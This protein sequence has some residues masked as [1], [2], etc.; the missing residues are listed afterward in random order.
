[1]YTRFFTGVRELP[2]SD[3]AHFTQIDYDRD[4]AFVAVGCDAAGA[5]EIHGVARAC[6]DPDNHAA[7]FAV[8]VRSDL[9][10]QGLGTLLMRK[11]IRY[12]RERGTRELWGDVMN[13]NTAMLQL[14]RSLGFRV[15][16]TELNIETVAL[17]LQAP[18]AAPDSRGG[19]KVEAAK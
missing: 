3:L 8:L 14:S 17:D 10:G 19:G 5:G 12:C 4:M 2:D 13:D 16:G 9:K 15:R 6:A 7:E 1:M 18:A 11:L